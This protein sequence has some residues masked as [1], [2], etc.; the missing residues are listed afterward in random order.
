MMS[1]L[2]V[3]IIVLSVPVLLSAQPSINSA[4]DYTIGSV[5]K[6]YSCNPT[7][8]GSSGANQ[9]W[10]FSFLSVIDSSTSSII[11]QTAPFTFFTANIVKKNSDSTFQYF[12]QTATD[13]F[14]LGYIDS[15]SSSNGGVFTFNNIYLYAERPLTMSTFIISSNEDTGTSMGYLNIYNGGNDT[16]VADAYGTL[17]LPNGTYTNTIRIKSIESGGTTQSIGGQLVGHEQY[18]EVTYSW[19]DNNHE[20]PLLVIDSTVV[21]HSG[22]NPQVSLKYLA[23]EQSPTS[24]TNIANQQTGA[25]SAFLNNDGLTIKGLEDKAYHLSMFDVI[26][27]HVYQTDIVADNTTM[28]V[29]FNNNLAAGIYLLSLA[30]KG[31]AGINTIKIV[32]Q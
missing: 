24:V 7:A 22:T 3:L 18:V 25:L 1:K 28:H 6:Y 30:E 8:T 14:Y 31:K 23:S 10:N 16:T 15:S 13:N 29:A 20:S 2:Y 5:F 32:K 26:G 12:Y 19:Y 4:Q 17:I 21:G 11:Q 9:T 27:Q